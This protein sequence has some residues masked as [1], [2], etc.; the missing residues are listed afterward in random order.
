MADG[1]TK[2]LGVIL[3]GGL[4][5]RMG[6]G[7]KGLLQIGGQSLLSHVIDRLDLGFADLGLQ[8]FKNIAR[9]VPVFALAIKA[10]YP[11]P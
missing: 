5:T 7:D 6:G 11:A 1:I 3:A 9:P 10:P 8:T 4:A 2:P